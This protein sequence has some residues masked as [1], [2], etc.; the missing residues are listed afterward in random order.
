[1]Q[2]TGLQRD[3]TEHLHFHVHIEKK[4]KKKKNLDADL[5][6]YTKINTKWIIDL[7]IKCKIIK[8]PED[9]IWENLDNLGFGEEFFNSK[10]TSTTHE[11]K[12]NGK[13]DWIKI[14]IFHGK[15]LLLRE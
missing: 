13:L 5:I 7:Q 12:K 3:M 15:R 2:S 1:M 11:R 4:K 6:S 8:L 14:K 10:T 9:N